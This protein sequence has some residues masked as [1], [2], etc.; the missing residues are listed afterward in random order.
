MCP[1]SV[2]VFCVESSSC[3]SYVWRHFF[4]SPVQIQTWL[5]RLSAYWHL[6]H[7]MQSP[8]DLSAAKSPHWSETTRCG[9]PQVSRG[10]H[11]RP[12]FLTRRGYFGFPRAMVAHGLSTFGG[13][14]CSLQVFTHWCSVTLTKTYQHPELSCHMRHP[15]RVT[16]GEYPDPDLEVSIIQQRERFKT[17][18]GTC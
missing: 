8:P 12:L 17:K 10:K 3:S 2:A 13:W 11:H 5:K 15:K 1:T 6:R 16:L 4:H 14:R 18:P 9:R 7:E